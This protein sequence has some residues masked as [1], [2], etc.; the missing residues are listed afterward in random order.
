MRLGP[1]YALP[2][3]S[4]LGKKAIA[5]FVRESMNAHPLS[6]SEGEFLTAQATVAE[7][8]MCMGHPLRRGVYSAGL[9]VWAV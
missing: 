5:S 4:E 8:E 3:V 7:Y 1:N 2:S 9:R 6:Y